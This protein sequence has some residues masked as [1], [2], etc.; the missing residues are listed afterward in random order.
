MNMEKDRQESE[1]RFQSQG[2]L[3]P[4]NLVFLQMN[5]VNQAL[6]QKIETL[7]E[8]KLRAHIFWKKQ[9]IRT[10]E[11]NIKSFLDEEYKEK[12]DK[13]LEEYD[14]AS[15]RDKVEVLHKLHQALESLLYRQG[16]WFSTQNY[17]EVAPAKKEP[18]EG[19]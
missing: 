17:F 18:R 8:D 3:K 5:R 2:K 4:N 19:D 11:N 16:L 7:E 14:E 6:S 10:L 13:L 1:F 9:C 15:V 12:R